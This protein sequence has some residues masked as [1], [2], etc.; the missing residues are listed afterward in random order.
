MATG[1]PEGAWGNSRMKRN[2]GSELAKKFAHLVVV[3]QVLETSYRFGIN[4]GI[5]LNQQR[6]FEN[7]SQI[8]R[9]VK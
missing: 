3:R 6:H 7:A 5:I 2:C 9:L 1:F 4:S 8:I